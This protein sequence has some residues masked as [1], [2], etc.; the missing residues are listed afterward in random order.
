[1][2]RAQTCSDAGREG[3]LT[4]VLVWWWEVIVWHF[5]RSDLGNCPTQYARPME[6][7]LNNFSGSSLHPKVEI[8]HPTTDQW[9]SQWSNI[10]CC[11]L[12]VAA[13]TWILWRRKNSG[14]L[15]I[16][17]EGSSVLHDISPNLGEFTIM[18]PCCGDFP[19]QPWIPLVLWSH[20]S[21][22]GIDDGANGDFRL[23]DLRSDRTCHTS[24]MLLCNL[25]RSRQKHA[26]R[27]QHKAWSQKWKNLQKCVTSDFISK[28]GR[29]QKGGRRKWRKPFSSE[30]SSN[31]PKEHWCDMI[32]DSG[33]S[34]L[35]SEIW[36]G[37]TN[38]GQRTGGLLGF[39]FSCVQV[40]VSCSR[41]SND[42]HYDRFWECFTYLNM[43]RMK[44][45]EL[46]AK[47]EGYYRTG[48]FWTT[49]EDWIWGWD[50]VAKKEYI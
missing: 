41:F 49:S 19:D 30:E 32:P 23:S 44:S 45:W 1:M 27:G 17:G 34:D 15:S 36:N 12:D 24:R 31:F 7:E 40:N 11:T 20:F 10:E 6:H 46:M 26:Y 13:N 37:K 33:H 28:S 38:S 22:S 35:C 5:S 25:I 39:Y 50:N 47:R 42:S 43:D 48:S 18:K 21:K 9:C 3:S 2:W 14:I 4:K 29:I 8:S 16:W